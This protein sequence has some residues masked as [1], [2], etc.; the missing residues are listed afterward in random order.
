MLLS[1]KYTL[2][3]RIV[4]YTDVDREMWKYDVIHLGFSLRIIIHDEI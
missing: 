3:T 1:C 4:N 2:D